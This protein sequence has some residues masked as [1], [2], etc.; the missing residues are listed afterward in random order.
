MTKRHK[1]AT[2][3][4]PTER[5]LFISLEEIQQAVKNKEQ[6]LALSFAVLIKHN[7]ANSRYY[8]H[9]VRYSKAFLRIGADKFKRVAALAEKYGYITVHP[10]GDMTARTLRHRKGQNV[11]LTLAYDKNAKRIKPRTE[12]I[13]KENKKEN[14]KNNVSLVT[15][16]NIEKALRKQLIAVNI[17]RSN[18]KANVIENLVNPQG[19]NALAKHKQA[20]RNAKRLVDAYG[21]TL[22]D[23]HRYSIA[24]GRTWDKTQTGISNYA[25]AK[26][27]GQCIHSTRMLIK[28]LIKENVISKV[29]P[30]YNRV[31]L[32]EQD[33]RHFNKTMTGCKLKTI[34]GSAMLA[35]QYPN[36][37]QLSRKI[38]IK[39]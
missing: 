29:T 28:E 10:N 2:T 16:K 14:K 38:I 11:M 21:R 20:R 1:R 13:N 12:K 36:S 35:I 39:A 37:Y 19:D 8:A 27:A 4:N 33:I 32:H 5:R 3:Q 18:F 24:E 34:K 30:N 17:E 25:L 7:Y 23:I 6:L 22:L 26:T 15:I 31:E 9:S